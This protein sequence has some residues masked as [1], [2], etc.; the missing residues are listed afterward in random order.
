MQ[1]GRQAPTASIVSSILLYRGYFRSCSG[2]YA[3]HLGFPHLT[4]MAVSPGWSRWMSCCTVQSC[5]AS[6]LVWL[7]QWY[8]SSGTKD[9]LTWHNDREIDRGDR[10]QL[11]RDALGNI[12]F[13]SDQEGVRGAEWCTQ[14]FAM[15]AYLFVVILHKGRFKQRFSYF[16]LLFFS[17]LHAA[18]SWS[19]H[20]DSFSPLFYLV[21]EKVNIVVRGVGY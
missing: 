8:H 12:H 10:E 21:L 5:T 11:M 1:D 20:C 15:C 16:Y 9:Q 4:E 7:L 3:T 13:L 6:C 18:A 14:V 2:L 17:P 19:R